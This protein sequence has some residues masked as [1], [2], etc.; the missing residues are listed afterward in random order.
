MDNS[1][2]LILR[3]LSRLHSPLLV[4]GA[5]D[6]TLCA[7]LGVDDTILTEQF[8]QATR[9][10]QKQGVEVAFGCDDR[11]LDQRQYAQALVFMAKSREE[12]KMRLALAASHLSAKGELLLV[13]AKREGIAGAGKVLQQQWPQAQKLDSARHCQLWSVIPQTP[14]SAFSIDEW[15]SEFDVTISGRTMKIQALPG[16]FSSGRLDPGTR[17]LIET[18]DAAPTT[19]VLD[20][21]CGAG[22][23]GA[24]LARRY[25][26]PVDLVD[27][28]AQAVISSRETLR[29]NDLNGRV[30]A[31]D[32]L[33]EVKGRYGLIVTNPPFHSG[34][35]LDTGI[36]ERFLAAAAAHLLPGGE[37]RLVANAFLPYQP[38]IESAVGPCKVLAQDNRFKVYSAVRLQRR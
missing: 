31:S 7:E 13:G 32:G 3:N 16:V 18:F 20:F 10:A 21:A 2:Q 24:W 11:E 9:L 1:S 30:W 26:V 37:L 14:A 8:A 19:P 25:S 27:A 6:D 35:K 15:F 34:V 22:I 12:L 5:P 17:M 33:S 23:I 36:T 28:Q 4:I 38:L 29:V